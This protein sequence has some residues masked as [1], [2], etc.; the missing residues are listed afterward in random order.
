MPAC[1]C[2]AW[3]N[4]YHLRS[5]CILFLGVLSSPSLSSMHAWL[6]WPPLASHRPPGPSGQLMLL[7]AMPA[8][9]PASA[10][11]MIDIHACIV[12]ISSIYVF[13]PSW[14]TKFVERHPKKKIVPSKRYMLEYVYILEPTVSKTSFIRLSLNALWTVWDRFCRRSSRLAKVL[15]F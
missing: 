8:P 1:L 13:G 3:N 12:T 10:S 14:M 15:S 9:V 2:L 5:W 6:A 4:N 7:V 11:S